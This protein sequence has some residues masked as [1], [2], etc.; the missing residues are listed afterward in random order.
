MNAKSGCRLGEAS[1]FQSALALPCRRDPMRGDEIELVCGGIKAG[2][3]T[4]LTGFGSEPIA[5]FGEFARNLAAARC[6]AR[7]GPIVNVQ[8]V[9]FD[10]GVDAELRHQEFRVTPGK[11]RQFSHV[12]FPFRIS[13][14]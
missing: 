10:P 8:P 4:A 13:L 5:K 1:Q 6:L 3:V 7:L 11:L 14:D 12:G 9:A 2:G